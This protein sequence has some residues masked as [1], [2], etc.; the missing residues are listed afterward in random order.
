MRNSNTLDYLA[1]VVRVIMMDYFPEERSLAG[2]RGGTAYNY[3]GKLCHGGGSC[4]KKAVKTVRKN[5]S[6][7]MPRKRIFTKSVKCCEHKRNEEK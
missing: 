7:Q 1:G 5:I 3:F 4:T 2:V 6:W